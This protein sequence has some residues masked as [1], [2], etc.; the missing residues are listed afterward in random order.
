ML[1]T[2]A[3]SSMRATLNGSLPDECGVVRDIH[4]SNGAGGQTSTPATVAIV[5]CRVSPLTDTIRNPELVA[6]ERLV[7]TA[8]WI[9]TLPATTNVLE[10]DRIF[11]AGREFEVAAVLAPRSW[12]IGRRLLCRLVNAGAG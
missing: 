1:S 9:V 12:E 7:P 6:A 3:I 5:A 4:A 2:A 10:T 8:P 11:S